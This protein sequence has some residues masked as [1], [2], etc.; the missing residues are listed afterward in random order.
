[1]EL[2]KDLDNDGLTFSLAQ[3]SDES[4]LKAYGLVF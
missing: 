1:M 2:A 4:R 3:S